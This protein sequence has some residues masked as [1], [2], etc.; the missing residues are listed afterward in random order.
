M[1]IGTIVGLLVG[2]GVVGAA[3]IGLVALARY[4]GITEVLSLI[5]G[6]F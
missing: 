6:F 4:T 1:D 5:S 2:I 3:G